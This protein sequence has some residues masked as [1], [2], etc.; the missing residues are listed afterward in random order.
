VAVRGICGPGGVFTWL[1]WSLT[2]EVSGTE[3]RWY[4]GPGLWDYRVALFD[5]ESVRIVPITLGVRRGY[6]NILKSPGLRQ[7]TVSGRDA[8]ELSLKTGDICCIGTDDPQGLAAALG[9]SG[10]A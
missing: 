1:F 8:V 10:P 2:V 4:F 6:P 3:I 7:Y 9:S 5:I